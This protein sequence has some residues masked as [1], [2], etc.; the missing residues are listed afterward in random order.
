MQSMK[1]METEWIVDVPDT[2][3][4][5]AARKISGGEFVQAETGSSLSNRLRSPDFKMENGMNVMKGVGVLVSEKGHDLRLDSS[6]KNIPGDDFKGRRSTIVFPPRESSYSSQNH[7]L[8]RKGGREK[9][10]CQGPKPFNCPRRV[11]KGINI[12]VDSPSKPPHCQ[13]NTVIPK[14]EYDHKYRSQMVFPHVTT[15]DCKIENTSTE[16][17]ARYMSN[18]P[19]RPIMNIKGKE[20]VAEE[21]FKDAGLSMIHKKGIEKSN[22]T[23]NQHEK[24]VSDTRRF[25]NSPKAT[26]H[27]RL[28]RNGCISP[29][30]TAIKTKSSAERSEK[31]SSPRAV[32][33]VDLG[34]MPSS[35]PSCLI[36]IKDI[37]AEENCSNKDKGKGIMRQPSTSRDDVGAR[38][39][40]ASSR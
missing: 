37:V 20:K 1:E 22:N 33:R 27:K 32:D 16:Q 8:L 25:V 19:K 13:E 35:S 15:K 3:D 9:Y 30:N 12:S 2:P 18:A 4:R 11:D 31:S 23:S 5:L 38:V 10:S 7:L 14:R 21:S 29:L 17:S 26:G 28:V 6:S 34:N 39:I 40:C 24:Q 36:D